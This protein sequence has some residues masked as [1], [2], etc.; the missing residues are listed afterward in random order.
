MSHIQDV[1]HS[2]PL[3]QSRLDG[4]CELT[5][6][7]VDVCLGNATLVDASCVLRAVSLLERF[8]TAHVAASQLELS[9]LPADSDTASQQHS[10]IDDN[11]VDEAKSK[12]ARSAAKRDVKPNSDKSAADASASRQVG[13]ALCRAD[14]LC[15]LVALC[16]PR[17][18]VPQFVVP[19]VRVFAAARTLQALFAGDN[20][21]VDNLLRY[22]QCGF[23]FASHVRTHIATLSQD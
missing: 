16:A 8:W 7:C 22:V 10:T 9:S 18:I 12:K 20:A 1:L 17:S 4:A 11:N 15:D 14:I 23:I 13:A 6:M 2:K 19:N 3:D 5:A 21:S